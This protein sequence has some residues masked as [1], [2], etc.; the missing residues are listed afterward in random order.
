MEARQMIR[1]RL[2]RPTHTERAC[3]VC[4]SLVSTGTTLCSRG[5]LRA[6]RHELETT[7]AALRDPDLDDTVRSSL[8]VRHRD[9]TAA[10]IGWCP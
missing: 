5:C 4:R 7:T 3:L 1:T 9:L 8:A 2:A 6:A 10:V